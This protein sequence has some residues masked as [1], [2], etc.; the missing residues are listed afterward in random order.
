MWSEK[1]EFEMRDARTKKKK[2]KKKNGSAGG[3]ERREKASSI[4]LAPDAV[5]MTRVVQYVQLYPLW[6]RQVAWPSSQDRR[7]YS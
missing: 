3:V 7:V 6:N 4:D 5:T 2:I 1:R